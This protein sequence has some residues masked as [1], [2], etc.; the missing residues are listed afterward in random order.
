[1]NDKER[2]TP[3]QRAQLKRLR[4]HQERF[5]HSRMIAGF[6]RWMASRYGR[7]TARPEGPATVDRAMI[8]ERVR[9]GLARA[10]S[11][12]KRLGRPPIASA[13]EKRT[14]EALATPGRPGIRVI[15]ERS[16]VNPSTVQRI[17]R[18]FDGASVAGA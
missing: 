2:L 6:C 4:Q 18:P 11:K 5:N 8:Q 1:M 12:G 17:S 7:S 13:L 16:G 3:E 10:R 14:R 15:A 9:A